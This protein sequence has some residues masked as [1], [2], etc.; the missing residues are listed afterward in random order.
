MSARQDLHSRAQNAILKNIVENFKDSQTDWMKNP[1]IRAKIFNSAFFKPANAVLI[2]GALLAAGCTSLLVLPLLALTSPLWLAAGALAPLALGALAEA[3]YLYYAVNNEESHAAAVAEM[4][5]PQVNFNPNVIKNAA[6]RAKVD[7]ALEY[8][9]RIDD[10]V[11]EVPAGPLRIRLEHATR[12]ATQW[13]QAVFNLA[14]QIDGLYQNDVIGRDLKAVP[15]TI[16]DLQARLALEDSPEVQQQLQ[17]TIANNERQLRTLQSLEDQMEK[18]N[19]QLDSTISSLGTIYSQLLLVG[20]KDESGSRVSRLQE[21]ISEQ[22]HRLEDLS[23]AMD[24]V[25]EVSY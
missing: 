25:Y 16:K 23:E 14:Q 24:E 5:R 8:W 6:L 10:A 3:L 19:Y 18:A 21:E 22:V 2:G 17:E 20:S 4:L 11:Q 13:L 7:K 15:K 9:S 1:G 12:E